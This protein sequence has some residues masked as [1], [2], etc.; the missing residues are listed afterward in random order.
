MGR[1]YCGHRRALVGRFPR[2][3]F[4]CG[5]VMMQRACILILVVGFLAGPAFA[6]QQWLS[7]KTLLEARQK[8]ELQALKLKQKL[9]KESLKNSSLPKAMRTQLKHELKQEQRTLCQKQKD[10]RQTLKD[11]QKLLD[12]ELKELGS[13]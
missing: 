9:A 2:F 1:E 7:E 5:D 12:L 10:E 6:G 11:R 3:L 4:G 13:Q 8:Q